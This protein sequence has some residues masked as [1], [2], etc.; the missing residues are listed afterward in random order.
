[1]PEVPPLHKPSEMQYRRDRVR[2]TVLIYRKEGMSTED[3]QKYWRDEH[4][5]CFAHLKIVKTNLLKYEQVCFDDQQ[6][7][8]L[9]SIS[10]VKCTALMRQVQCEF[11][12][13]QRRVADLCG[14]EFQ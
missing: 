1:M 5:Q 9:G 10:T 4:S 11:G 3:F 8:T 12:K 2:L 14:I 6:S 13:G 7:A